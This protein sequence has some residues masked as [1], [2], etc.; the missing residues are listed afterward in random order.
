[1]SLSV[2]LQDPAGDNSL[3]NGFPVLRPSPA[4]RNYHS[5]LQ[6]RCAQTR[7]TGIHIHTLARKCIPERRDCIPSKCGCVPAHPRR[8]STVYL[9][10][11]RYFVQP[12]EWLYRRR[13]TGWRSYVLVSVAIKAIQ[14]CWLHCG[15][16]DTSV[17]RVG[18]VIADG[19]AAVMLLTL[20]LIHFFASLCADNFKRPTFKIL[21]RQ[22][23]NCV[24]AMLIITALIFLTRRLWSNLD[25]KFCLA[26]IKEIPQV[27]I[28]TMFGK[29]CF[30][31]LQTTCNIYL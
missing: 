8:V 27:Q 3:G 20:A 12:N 14:R 29:H 7:A 5:L 30:T 16:L 21:F 6:R 11:C 9:A 13:S 10:R 28:G 22:V 25:Y 17:R 15:R 26:K 24:G 31:N 4:R 18:I 19:T 1:M 23:G 2:L